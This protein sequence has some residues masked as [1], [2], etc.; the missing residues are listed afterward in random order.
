MNYSTKKH[1]AAFYFLPFLSCFE[2]DRK[3][4]VG[5]KILPLAANESLPYNLV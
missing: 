2:K 4:S 5:L 1:L 3:N